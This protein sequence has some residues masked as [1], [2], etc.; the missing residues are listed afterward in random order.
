MDIITKFRLDGK[1]AIVTGGGMGIGKAIALHFAQVG[2]DVVVGELIESAGEATALEIRAL[3]RKGLSVAVDVTDSGQVAKL[4]ETTLKEFGRIDILVNNAGKNNPLTPALNITEEDWDRFIRLNL[5]S[6]FLCSKAAGRAMVAQRKG[7][8]INISSAA[9]I[10]ADPGLSVYGAA[11]AGV[12]NFTETLS[13]EFARYNIRVNCIIPG[14]IETGLG[15]AIRGTA[16]ERVERAG[17]PRGRI[18]QPEDIALA[19]VYLA[20]DAS[21]YLTGAC[22]EVKG[23]PITR[24]GDIEMFVERF[25]EL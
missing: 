15:V 24:K 19:A 16:R 3:G 20:S 18:G 2:A 17:I 21:D 9:G 12:I 25:P 10:R 8:I 6:A 7:N 11:K 23:G 14:A 5:T 4:I 22:I 1:V 13:I